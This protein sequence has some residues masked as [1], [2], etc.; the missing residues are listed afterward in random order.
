M[1]NEQK[2]IDIVIMK[3]QKTINIITALLEG[4]SALSISKRL[5]VARSYIYK[6]KD[7][8]LTAESVA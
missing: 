2:A 7:N 1:T 3:H 8:Y 6:V 4:E 5:G